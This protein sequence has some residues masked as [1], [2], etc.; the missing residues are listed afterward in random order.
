[1]TDQDLLGLSRKLRTAEGELDKV[2]QLRERHVGLRDEVVFWR[3]LL[4][5]T[6]S[7]Q[8]FIDLF[9]QRARTERR[10]QPQ[11]EK[12]LSHVPAGLVVRVLD[13]GS[14]PLTHVGTVSDR[15]RVEITGVDPLADEY[16]ALCEEFGLA[17]RGVHYVAGEAETLAKRFPENYFD[18][19]YCRNALD[20]TCDPLL[21]I[22]QMVRVLK[23]DGCCWLTHSTDEGEK[24]RYRGLH[25]WNFRAQDDGDL[26]I[27]APGT[28]PVT[29]RQQLR[30]LAIVHAT[31]SGGWHAVLIRLV[32]VR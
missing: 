13:V 22:R 32:P 16:S 1:M 2:G 12:L 26:V 11:L 25:R 30:D 19:V 21:G 20:H 7:N 29:L 17:R 5:R 14:G 27:S 15:W 31:T 4:D 23:A 24:Q 28:S 18:L 9:H 8:R 10:L 3:S 6:N